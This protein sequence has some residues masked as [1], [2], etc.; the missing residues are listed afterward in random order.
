VVGLHAGIRLR[1]DPSV[2][3]ELVVDVHGLRAD[4]PLEGCARLG[5]HDVGLLDLRD[6]I[7]NEL[8]RLA[9]LDAFDARS[10]PRV[11]EPVAARA[12]EVV[13]EDERSPRSLRERR[14]VEDATTAST[15]PGTRGGIWRS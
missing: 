6:R 14:G 8:A 3:P 1:R 9:E 13:A 12:A 2:A 5:D 7:E 15:T 10:L 4:H 11:D